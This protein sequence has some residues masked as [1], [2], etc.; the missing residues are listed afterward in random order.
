MWR[1]TTKSDGDKD[2]VN[3]SSYDRIPRQHASHIL[4]SQSKETFKDLRKTFTQEQIKK[5]TERCLGCGAVVADPYQCVG[6]GICT[7]KCKFDA[8]SLVRKYDSSGLPLEEMKLAVVKHAIKR[9]GR[10]I[11][12]KVKVAF[13]KKG[14][15]GN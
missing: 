6:C 9:Q 3:L 4:G 5:E 2:N 15:K 1:T 14:S 11:R 10:I 7:T 12:K 8:L 13:M